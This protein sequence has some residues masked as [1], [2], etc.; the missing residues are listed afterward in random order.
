MFTVKIIPTYD[1]ADFEVLYEGEVILMGTYLN[2]SEDE[3]I[4]IAKQKMD[5]D[6]IVLRG[7][8]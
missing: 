3:L 2:E 8:Q 1:G 5:E 7:D 4:D 6:F